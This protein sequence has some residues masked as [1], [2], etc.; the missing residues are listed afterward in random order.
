MLSIRIHIFFWNRENW[1]WVELKKMQMNANPQLPKFSVACHIIKITI[2]IKC[3]LMVDY[4]FTFLFDAIL[5]SWTSFSMIVFDSLPKQSR[6]LYSFW[7]DLIN[8]IP[9]VG[10]WNLLVR[11]FVRYLVRVHLKW[12]V[13][14]SVLGCNKKRTNRGDST[15]HRL[16]SQPR[17]KLWTWE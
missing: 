14:S 1:P 5:S 4:Y 16:K 13:V 10:I 17:G 3:V 6:N 7:F 11:S 8:N 2:V 15:N 12:T 9:R